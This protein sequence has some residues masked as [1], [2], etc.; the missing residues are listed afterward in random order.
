MPRWPGSSPP[1]SPKRQ[2][3]AATVLFSSPHFLFAF[4]PAVIVGAVAAAKLG[5][6]AM[7]FVWLIAASL[8]FYAWWNPPY[9]LL[10][11]TSV[12]G[13]YL[14]GRDLTRTQSRGLLF[15][16]VIFN[17][18]LIVYFKYAWFLLDAVND[19]SGTGFRS[20]DIVLIL[21]NGGFEGIYER[22]PAALEAAS[23]S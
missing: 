19:L 22:L 17:L 13:N 1:T 16:G 2:N 4:L 7:A 21:S 11:C 14:F 20:G 5:G 9:L 10:L 6:K 23:S 18:G 15:V 12:V 8:F 3:K